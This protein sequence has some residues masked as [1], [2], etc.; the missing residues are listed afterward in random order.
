MPLGVLI[1]LLL[2]SLF[3]VV[4][5]DALRVER[6]MRLRRTRLLSALEQN[7]IAPTVTCFPMMGVE[8]YIHNPGPFYAPYSQSC[9]L[10][11]FVVNPHPRFAALA[12]NIR[13]RRTE[14]VHMTVP[15]FHD[16]NTPEFLRELVQKGT[17]NAVVP[18]SLTPS[19]SPCKTSSSSA[20]CEKVSSDAPVDP[21]RA[22][23][24]PIPFA[25]E[26]DTNIHM[27]AMGFGMG[28]CCLVIPKY[29]QRTQHF[30]DEFFFC[31]LYSK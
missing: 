23:T 3:V 29:K 19:S 15:L 25:L 16:V 12:T 21:A 8:D 10:P 18:E 27:D 26:P 11:D 9:Y 22:S 2:Q 28:M 20:E 4:K 14:K 7:E 31:F 17:S 5:S 1:L 6:N 24:Y 13:T 30:C